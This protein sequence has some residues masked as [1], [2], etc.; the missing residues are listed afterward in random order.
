MTARR[1][2]PWTT[3]AS[4]WPRLRSCAA[5]SVPPTPPSRSSRTRSPSAPPTRSGAE[6]LKDFLA[7]PTALTFVRGDAAVAAKA[8]ADYARTIQL[9]PFKG[10]VMD[11]SPLD[12]EQIRALSRPARPRSPLWT[13]RGDRRLARERPGANP[14]GAA[15]AAS[16]WPSARFGRRRSPARSRPASPHRGRGRCGGRGPRR[17]AR[18][19]RE[20]AGRP[21]PSG[22]PAEAEPRRGGRQ[23]ARG[24]RRAEEAEPAAEA[25]AAEPRRPRRPRSPRRS[26]QA[27]PAEEPE[28]KD[29][30]DVD[31]EAESGP[32]DAAADDTKED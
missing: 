14:L 16:P 13:A 30:N 6:G 25:Q 19:R 28:Q 24:E 3:G 21:R 18:R 9:L 2:S 4:P 27:E 29:D 10:G 11:G 23:P 17:G 5:T 7:G 1:S 8:I 12:V 32:E 22:C 20:A 31:A 26:T 15:W